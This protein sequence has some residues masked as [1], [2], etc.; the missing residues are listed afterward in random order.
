MAI[1]I[2]PNRKNVPKASDGNQPVR[3]Q[4]STAKVGSMILNGHRTQASKKGS[5][6]ADCNK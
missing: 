4:D 1:N 2:T 6:C 5:G 3:F